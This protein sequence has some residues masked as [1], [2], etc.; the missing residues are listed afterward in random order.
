M[1]ALA[2]GASGAGADTI[3]RTDGTAKEGRILQENDEE[4]VLEMTI[5]KIKASIHIPRAEIERIERSKPA[6]EAPKPQEPTREAAE[7]ET[8]LKSGRE[9]L[10]A[11]EYLKAAQMLAPLL[12][13][14]L[15]RLNSIER[16]SV[17]TDLIRC[18]ECSGDWDNARSAYEDFLKCPTIDKGEVALI[19]VK[20]RFLNENP[21]G[22]IDVSAYSTSAGRKPWD[23]RP[24]SDPKIMEFA[25]RSEAEKILYEAQRMMSRADAQAQNDRFWGIAPVQVFVEIPK[26]V[27]GPRQATIKKGA[28][29]TLYEDAADEAVEAD[30]LA[31]GISAPLRLKIAQKQAALLDEAAAKTRKE[32]LE[33]PYHAASGPNTP[34]EQLNVTEEPTR[35][36]LE[37]VSTLEA[38]ED[39]KL[40]V[41]EPF[42][43]QLIGQLEKY[44]K[45]REQL[46]ECRQR[47]D[48]IA[49]LFA[50]VQKAEELEALFEEYSAKARAS[51]PS[52]FDYGYERFLDGQNIYR[53]K[54]KSAI[55][56]RFQSDLCVSFCRKAREVGVKRIALLRE[57]P[58]RPQFTKEIQVTKD[59]MTQI[60]ALEVKVLAERGTI[61]RAAQQ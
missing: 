30:Y 10:E 16:R 49:E 11:R 18:Y 42:S 57:F 44:R 33:H 4:I 27:P 54:P 43:D 2:L 32:M 45:E 46:A 15:A 12:N 28:A 7:V 22:M 23:L 9:L 40:A 3:Y 29:Y 13:L 41:L 47:A 19:R 31:P 26:L 50:A 20:Q 55:M 51:Q 56:W 17:L 53:F 14:P 59:K 58:D 1:A 21:G 25:L 60:Y 36:Y 6:E 5:G 61:G 8:A 37:I 35:K 39:A 52:N 24:L 38:L 48:K 34:V